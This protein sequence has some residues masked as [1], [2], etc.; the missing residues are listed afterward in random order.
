MTGTA[1]RFA[2]RPYCAMRLKWAAARGEV[3]MAATKDETSNINKG[4]SQ[5]GRR[6]ARRD[7]G[8]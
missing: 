4:R 1:S 6:G 3:A 7:H 8:P 2:S 5:K